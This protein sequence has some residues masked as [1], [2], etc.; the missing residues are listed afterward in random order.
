MGALLPTII[1]LGVV[2][3]ILATI[4]TALSGD[5]FRHEEDSKTHRWF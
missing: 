3:I 5:E 2:A 1:M 4:V